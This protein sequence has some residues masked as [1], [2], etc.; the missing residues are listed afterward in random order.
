MT[1]NITQ[2]LCV[3][4]GLKKYFLRSFIFIFTLSLHSLCALIHPCASLP[5]FESHRRSGVSVVRQHWMLVQS[6]PRAYAVDMSSL[7]ALQC[8]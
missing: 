6:H 8:A 3:Y 4:V 7:L 5:F 1:T 2:H